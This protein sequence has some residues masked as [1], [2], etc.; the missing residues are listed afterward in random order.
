MDKKTVEVLAV[1]E[2]VVNLFSTGQYDELE[3]LTGGVE[4][5]A[6]DMRQEAERWPFR[7][8]PPPPGM[9]VSLIRDDLSDLDLIES[10]N[11]P[12]R[13]VD[14]HFYTEEEGRSDLSTNLW[15][16]D[17]PD[18]SYRIEINRIDVM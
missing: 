17:Q 15:I 11:P 7:I 3:R 12:H 16:T 14:V 18:G 9:L 10:L 5:S 13:D 4:L 1:I 6:Q 2:N 8:V